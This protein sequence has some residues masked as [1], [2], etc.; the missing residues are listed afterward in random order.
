VNILNKLKSNGA[1]FGLCLVGALFWSRAAHA[2]VP[3]M[4]K[5]GWVFSF[6]GRINSFLSGGQGDN[7]PNPTPGS[8]HKVMGS[9][10][11]EG[12]GILDV[13]WSSTQVN[14]N[15]KFFALR[16][17]S[18][19]YGNVLGF[20]LTRRFS[21]TTYVRG[22]ISLWS[23]V[24]TLG[25]DKWAP[26]TAEAREGYFTAVGTFGSLTVGR[27]LGWLGRTSYEIDSQYGHGYGVGL[28]CTDVLGPACGHIGTGELFPGYSAG[29]AYSTPDIGGLQVHAGLY[30]PIVFNPGS[31][32]DWS[33]ASYVRPE[34]SVTLDRAFGGLRLKIGLEG[35]YQTIG[36]IG[37]DPVTMAPVN[38]TSSIWG[39]SGGARLE[40]GPVRLGVSGFTGRGISLGFAGARSVATSDNDAGAAGPNGPSYKLRTFTGFYTQGALVFGRMQVGVGY[41]LGLVNQLPEDKVN[42]NLSVIHAQVGASLS[43]Y[44]HVSDAVVIG[45]DY[46][47]YMATWY[48]APLVDP[49]TNAVTGKLDGE[50]QS[51]NFFSAGATYHW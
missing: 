15:N 42:G 16:V 47:R 43:L 32:S 33:H 34:G 8:M 27:T 51:L 30:D 45:V 3:L 29:F 2:E 36:R 12:Q 50:K 6:D 25:R 5:D 37:N 49:T 9:D 26:I 46:F 7:F 24:E 13:G 35:M 41:G 28:P 31:S 48:G 38:I 44:Y 11:G 4:E 17:R 19:M 21:D 18:G 10:S 22:Y 39:A 14:T 1:L 40:A 20:A 23:T